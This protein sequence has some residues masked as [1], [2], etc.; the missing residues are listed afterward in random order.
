MAALL[1]QHKL[2]Y[3][4]VPK[5]ACTS[6]KHFFFELENRRPFERFA[7]NGERF[8][9]HTLYPGKSFEEWDHAALA[10][11]LKLAV[12]RDPVTRF[13]SCYGNRVLHHNALDGWTFALS[14]EDQRKGIVLRPDLDLY[15]THF[16]RY[17]ELSHEIRAHSAPMV[18]QL[19][20]NPSCFDHLFNIGELNQFVEAVRVHVG[21]APDMGRKQTG[22]PKFSPNDLSATQRKF[23]MDFYAEDYRVFGK[24]L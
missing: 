9:I 2:A 22:G 11:Y 16:H 8:N 13:L 1:P 18:Q 14:P 6:I 5:V 3:F 24:Y 10:D 15:V 7:A 17:R 23:I 12:V 4:S 19:G 20:N 21:H